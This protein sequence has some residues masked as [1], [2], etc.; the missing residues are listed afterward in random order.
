MATEKPVCGLIL[1]IV[2]LAIG[3]TAEQG[4]AKNLIVAN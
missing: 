1:I 2:L 3:N 4:T